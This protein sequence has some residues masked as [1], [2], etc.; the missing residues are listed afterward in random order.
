MSNVIGQP[1][2]VGKYIYVMAVCECGQQRLVQPTE[3]A[4]GNNKMC[5]SCSIRKLANS[6]IERGHGHSKSRTYSSWCA[7]IQR[8]TNENTP[9]FH[10][11]GGRGI[12]I[13]DRWQ[14]FENFLADMGERPVGTSI[15]RIDPDG[16]YEPGNCRWATTTEQA[17]NRR[18]IRLTPDLVN[19]IRGRYE[20]G[21][22]Q[23]SLAERFQLNRGTVSGIVNG[24]SWKD[25]PL[26]SVRRGYSDRFG[27]A[28]K[29][30]P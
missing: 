16:H 13:C 27:S 25:I 28:P 1:F 24:S 9:T 18:G 22:H 15:D 14:S 8:C 11:Y 23:K 19:E 17:R 20:H 30:S 5:K 12:F 3:L 2:K 4:K 10:H 26:C 6:A 29:V 21:E 7:M